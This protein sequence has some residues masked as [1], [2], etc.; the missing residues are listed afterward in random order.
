MKKLRL[1]LAA[2]AIACVPT[3]CSSYEQFYTVPI[4]GQT[5]QCFVRDTWLG[6]RYAFDAFLSGMVHT[7]ER[8][9]SLP[10]VGASKARKVVAHYLE[11]T[12]PDRFV[13]NYIIVPDPCT[14]EDLHPT[15]CLR[16]TDEQEL[17]F[18]TEL[19]LA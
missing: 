19:G 13:V 17:V 18:N 5:V 1:A 11:N 9:N 15:T 7:A 2:L 16:P 6:Y 12:D 4:V 14:D 3:A 8:V 10:F